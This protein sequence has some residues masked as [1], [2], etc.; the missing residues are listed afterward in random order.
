MVDS[1]NN[2]RPGQYYSIRKSQLSSHFQLS[3]RC[4]SESLKGSESNSYW[5]TSLSRMSISFI[6]VRRRLISR[7]T[8]VALLSLI[9][10]HP[11]NEPCS[12]GNNKE[13]KDPATFK[14]IRRGRRIWVINSV[15]TT[16]GQELT[17]KTDL[18][19][20]VKFRRGSSAICSFWDSKI[21]ELHSNC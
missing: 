16:N 17:S 12:A 21:A 15:V 10:Y 19:A 3:E 8:T 11:D 2:V 5:I 13:I 9:I 6:Y 4:G 1:L 18:P 14:P 7:H 20:R